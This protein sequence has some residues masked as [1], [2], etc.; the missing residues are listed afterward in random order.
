MR[1]YACI[2]TSFRASV[3]PTHLSILPP[4]DCF[5]PPRGPVVQTHFVVADAHGVYVYVCVCVL[6]PDVHSTHMH[7]R[8]HAHIHTRAQADLESLDADV[9]QNLLKLLDIDD[10]E[11]LCLDYTVTENAMGEV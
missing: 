1:V 6:P 4:S 5:C 8:A 11:M 3:H 9:Y 7:A 2:N 10:V